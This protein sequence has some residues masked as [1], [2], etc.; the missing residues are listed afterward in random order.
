VATQICGIPE[1]IKDGLTGVLIPPGDP[2]A[3]A[4]ALAGLIRDPARRTALGAAG[5][6]RVRACF[7]MTAGIDLLARRFG[8]MPEPAA[9][10]CADARDFVEAQ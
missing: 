9:S 3:L 10:E 6:R 7:S 4:A 2:L 5:E 1:L 8:L